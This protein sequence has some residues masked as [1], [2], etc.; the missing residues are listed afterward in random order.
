MIVEKH[1]ISG[2]GK[3]GRFQ[4]KKGLV[5]Y[6]KGFKV[7]FKGNGKSSKGLRQGSGMSSLAF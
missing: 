1:G 7:Y 3:V 4:I 6:A 5:C 2:A